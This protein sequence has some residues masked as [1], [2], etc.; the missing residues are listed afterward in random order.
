MP[1]RLTEPQQ[2]RILAMYEQGHDFTAIDT[3]LDLHRSTVARHVNEATQ[4]RSLA[5]S[6]AAALTADEI[7]QFREL[8]YMRTQIQQLV[9]AARVTTCECGT[10]VLYLIGTQ[11]VRCSKC[12][13]VL[14]TDPASARSR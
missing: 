1:A 7:L 3:T 9:A 4:A 8:A 13:G 2:R 6:P 5:A 11:A 10:K 14:E 12:E